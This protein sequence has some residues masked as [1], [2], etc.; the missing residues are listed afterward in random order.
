MTRTCFLLAA[1]AWLLSALINQP[2]SAASRGDEP[3]APANQVAFINQQIESAW[4]DRG[5]TPSRPAEDGAWCR[6]VYLDLLGRVPSV[7][8]LEQ[9]VR[10]RSDDKKAKLVDR[11]LGEEYLAEYARNWT[12]EWTN[13]LVGRTGGATRDSLVSRAGTRQYL[14]RSFQKNKPADVMMRELVTATGSCQPG[15]ADFNGAANFLADKLADNGVQAT[16]KT[17]Q[18]FLGMAV[19]CTQCHNHPFNEY[20]QNQFWEM[21]AFFRQ[22]RLEPIRVARNQRV[23]RIVNRDF[24]GEGGDPAKAELYYELRNGKLKVAYPVFVDGT[25]LVSLHADRGEDFGDSGYLSDV[26]RREELANLIAASDEFPRAMVNRVWGH[27]LGYGFTKPVDDMGP[28]NAPSHPELLDYLASEFR[29]SSFN[30]KELMRWIVLSDAYGLSS[31]AARGNESDD[32]ALGAKPLFSRFYLRQMQAEQLYES[33]LVATRADE[34]LDYAKREQMKEDWLAQFN[35]A[36]GNDEN[37]EA[38][39]FNGS[40]PQALMLMNGDLIKQATECKEGSFL[41][42]VA[43]NPRLGNAKKIQLLY[44]AAL[45]RDPA[46]EE[47]AISNRILQA[48]EGDVP[49]ALQDV[50]WALLNTNEFILNH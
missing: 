22:T 20:K 46:K 25:S 11:L 44:L 27:F 5:L 8:E 41:H 38:T 30:L 47:L 12:T 2:V 37:G 50:W 24:A 34:S 17:S 33:L 6:R 15:D 32:P 10:D 48:R 42:Q 26:N 40:I 19:Q 13:L 49:A 9:F 23:A 36:F 21:N 29:T 3:A 43:T 31:R 4:Q 35:T 18:I 7:N 39:T 45:A 16:A 1:A 14:R 28:H